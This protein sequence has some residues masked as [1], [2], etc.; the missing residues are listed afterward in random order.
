MRA[1]L[2]KDFKDVPR[3]L[4]NL[5]REV[6][7]AIICITR[8]TMNDYYVSSLIHLMRASIS[9]CIGSRSFAREIRKIKDHVSNEQRL[10]GVSFAHG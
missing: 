6:M 7:S 2:R 8:N 3:I 4:Q 10:E 1:R 9:L 5:K